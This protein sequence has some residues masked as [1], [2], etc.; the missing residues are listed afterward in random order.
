MHKPIQP[1]SSELLHNEELKILLFTQYYMHDLIKNEMGGVTL[2]K[3][4]IW[5][6]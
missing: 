4:T 2:G 1:Q 5:K 3:D 6:I